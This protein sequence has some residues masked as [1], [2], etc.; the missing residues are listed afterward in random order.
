MSQYNTKLPYNR[1]LPSRRLDAGVVPASEDVKKRDFVERQ[2]EKQARQLVS[3]L[4]GT[5][6]LEAQALDQ[7]FLEEM[8]QKARRRLLEMRKK[9]WLYSSRSPAKRR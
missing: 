4:Q 2:A 7:D 9:R 6:G 5:M 8:F 3:M 1:R